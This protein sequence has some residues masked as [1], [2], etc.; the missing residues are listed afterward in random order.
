M[1]EYFPGSHKRP[2]S[3]VLE[4]SLVAMGRYDEP[5]HSA[6]PVPNG[7]WWVAEK[8]QWDANLIAVGDIIEFPVFDEN[9]AEL[10]H[11]MVRL[12]TAKKQTK[13]FTFV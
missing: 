9:D 12:C 3:G 13:P 4:L 10:G 11:L 5:R 2:A 7:V 6:R 1:P 8:H